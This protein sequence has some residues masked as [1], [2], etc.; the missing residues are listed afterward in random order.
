MINSSQ[1]TPS[2]AA[3]SIAKP[4]FE[5]GLLDSDRDA[6]LSDSEAR[7]LQHAQTILGLVYQNVLKTDGG[8]G[9]A[10]GLSWNRTQLIGKQQPVALV[11][12]ALEDGSVIPTVVRPTGREFRNLY[13]KNDVV[14]KYYPRV[15]LS[16]TL[17]YA[18]GFSRDLLVVERVDGYHGDYNKVPTVKEFKAVVSTPEGMEQLCQETFQALDEILSAPLILHDVDPPSGHNMI[19]DTTSG[20]FRL[21][22]VDTVSESDATYQEKFL[23]FLGSTVDRYGRSSIPKASIAYVMRTLQLYTAAHP[24][25][26]LVYESDTTDVPEY[27]VSDEMYPTEGELLYTGSEEYKKAHARLVGWWE[28]IAWEKDFPITW[29]KDFPVIKKKIRTG[30]Y[31]SKIR[32]GL[33]EA[34]GNDD[35]D[36]FEKIITELQKGFEEN[37]LTEK[38]FV[39]QA[40]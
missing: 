31:V 16:A 4:S 17:P 30:R 33:L 7:L 22:D 9:Q 27:A 11:D 10:E 32:P 24:D 25:E 23:K 28:S 36:G 21:F 20:H 2:E 5:L 14:R 12:F 1:D 19:Y 26:D 3:T 39:E 35:I 13:E 37:L 34:A 18:N 29:D 38:T 6:Q 8:S 15:F 40:S